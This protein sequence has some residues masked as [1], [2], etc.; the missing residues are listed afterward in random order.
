MP[1][2]RELPYYSK[3]GNRV[4]RRARVEQV[5]S[6]AQARGVKYAIM[7]V[8]VLFPNWPRGLKFYGERIG[9]PHL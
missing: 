8:P 5:Y 7:I 6:V 9:E 4:P 2:I 3:V 1:S